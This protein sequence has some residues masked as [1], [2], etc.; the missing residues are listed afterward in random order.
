MKR[1][2]FAFLLGMILLLNNLIAQNKIEY[3]E[4]KQI[5]MQLE[6]EY[7]DSYKNKNVE[8][9]EKYWNDNFIGWPEWAKEPIN[10]KEA[11]QAIGKRTK[12]IITSFKIRPQNIVL[13]GN[14][15]VVFYFIDLT[16]KN[17]NGENTIAT[18]RIVHTWIKE[19]EQWEI[20]GG[21]SAG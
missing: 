1:L 16:V 10:V 4:E 12:N 13:K 9:L 17:E 5:L 14:V 6:E 11:K 15:A 7:M 20:L 21:I 3:S 8:S 2:D 19:N 18:Y